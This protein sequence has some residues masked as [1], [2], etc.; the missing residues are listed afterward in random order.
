[1]GAN[2]PRRR[3]RRLLTAVCARLPG[4]GVARSRP[5]AS[6]GRWWFRVPAVL[7]VLVI[8]GAADNFGDLSTAAPSTSHHSSAA[9]N[10]L[11]PAKPSDK[12]W[13]LERI[14]FP[15]HGIGD[16]NDDFAG[17]ARITNTN[18]IASSA[19][20]TIT[21]LTDGQTVASLDGYA[22]NVSAGKTVS[23]PMISHD[24]YQPGPFTVVFQTDASYH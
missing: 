5:K 22:N 2:E 19:I 6:Y 18:K 10:A 16:G 12:G 20:F 11:V 14:R 3:S 21:V 7:M 17:A 8:F 9:A 1:M 24:D 4:I 13:V 15:A 23:V